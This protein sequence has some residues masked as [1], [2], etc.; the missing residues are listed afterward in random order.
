[1]Q[2]IE[3]LGETQKSFEAQLSPEKQENIRAITAH[4]GAHAFVS[5]KLGIP[6]MKIEMSIENDKQAG[7]IVWNDLKG[8]TTEMRGISYAAGLAGELVVLGEDYVRNNGF[9]GVR[10][11]SK[12]LNQLGYISQE[13]KARLLTE[14]LDV[15]ISNKDD[16]EK[17]RATL[18]RELIKASRKGTDRIL[19]DRDRLTELGIQ[20]PEKEA[21]H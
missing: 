6:L 11:D 13:D 3:L 17:F 19:L 1:M 10:T 21:L 9:K 16:F 18:E 2:A 4:E 20:K 12:R 8:I 7:R 5:L 14:A 15:L